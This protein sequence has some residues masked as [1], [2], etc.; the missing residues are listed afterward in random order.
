VT[1]NHAPDCPGCAKGYIPDPDPK[2]PR[3]HI[4]PATKIWPI[5]EWGAACGR[6]LRDKNKQVAG[7]TK[8][9]L[10]RQKK[11]VESDVE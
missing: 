4:N 11:G 6:G 8:A 5:S 1:G 2:R 9:Q 10:S 3:G 7:P